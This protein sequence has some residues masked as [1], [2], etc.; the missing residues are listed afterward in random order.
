MLAD[1]ETTDDQIYVTDGWMRVKLDQE[2]C[3]TNIRVHN[4]PALENVALNASVRSSSIGYTGDDP[5]ILVNGKAHSEDTRDYYDAERFSTLDTENSH[6]VEIEFLSAVNISYIKI[7]ATKDTA[8]REDELLRLLT[9]EDDTPSQVPNTDDGYWKEIESSSSGKMFGTIDFQVH[10]DV[11]EIGFISD[12]EIKGSISLK[13]IEVYGYLCEKIDIE[14]ASQ[15]STQGTHVASQAINLNLDDY[16]QTQVG[17]DEWL[18]IVFVEEEMMVEAVLFFRGSSVKRGSLEHPTI[19][20]P[21]PIRKARHLTFTTHGKDVYFLIA[22]VYAF[23]TEERISTAESS[24][25]AQQSSI[26]QQEARNAL[27][28]H[29]MTSVSSTEPGQWWKVD[30]KGR[31]LMKRLEVHFTSGKEYLLVSCHKKFGSEHADDIFVLHS[32][33]LSPPEPSHDS[34]EWQLVQYLNSPSSST[35]LIRFIEPITAHHLAVYTNS[36]G[37]LSIREVK[38]FGYVG[39]S[40]FHIISG[41]QGEPGLGK[42]TWKSVYS[43]PLQVDDDVIEVD[44]ENFDSTGI[45][46][47]SENNPLKFA[48]IKLYGYGSEQN[49]SVTASSS[50][51]GSVSDLID[52]SW[53]SMNDNA[54]LF[55]TDDLPKQYVIVA[56]GGNRLVLTD[57]VISKLHFLVGPYS[58]KKVTLDSLYWK[59][60]DYQESYEEP[61]GYIKNFYPEIFCNNL[62]IYSEGDNG[63]AIEEIVIYANTKATNLA[64]GKEMEQSSMLSDSS[65]AADADVSS[66]LQTQSSPYQWWR[67]H[68]GASYPVN[69][70]SVESLQPAAPLVR[71][72][73]APLAT[74]TVSSDSGNTAGNATD[75][76]I[77]AGFLSTQSLSDQWLLISL[78]EFYQ[79]SVIELYTP[80]FALKNMKLLTSDVENAPNPDPTNDY[81][82]WQ[83]TESKK[84][85]AI[86]YEE[87]VF[88]RPQYMSTVAVV[89]EGLNG[90]R[91]NEVKVIGEANTTFNQLI[92]FRYYVKLYQRL[93]TYTNHMLVTTSNAHATSVVLA[94]FT[95]LIVMQRRPFVFCIKCEDHYSLKAGYLRENYDD[96]Q[97]EWKTTSSVCINRIRNS[98]S[99]SLVSSFSPNCLQQGND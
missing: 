38:A 56:M 59:E 88:K 20:S 27:S 92:Q 43:Q 9:A 11:K 72:N 96:C 60:I 71:G 29:T 42:S 58:T 80:D 8:V 61:S 83:V 86:I 98:N 99:D 30:L 52:H 36:T 6:W 7:Y 28:S 64:I 1:G 67:I 47:V 69:V 4:T 46:I 78:P 45:A 51:S 13:E 49:L 41:S 75:G 53:Y 23:G 70:V 40:P 5:A 37:G 54:N 57:A 21:S 93:L 19:I 62:A 15:S 44:V 48:E 82:P 73:V 95:S 81:Q 18:D 34:P 77:D 79:I 2:Y 33:S 76:M 39:N 31:Y 14:E 65:F 55:A 50:A 3:L 91:L 94:R 87:F 68:L 84:T 74:A 10:P 35:I 63:I 97:H 85:G 90:I 32:E 26:C 17:A 66:F 12:S 22:E 16:Q 24:V 25:V 89:S